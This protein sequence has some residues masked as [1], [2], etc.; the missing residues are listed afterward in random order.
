MRRVVVTGLGLV[1]P[2]GADVETVWANLIAGKSGAGTITHFDASDQKCTIACEVKGPDHE[3]GFDPGKRV[4]HTAVLPGPVGLEHRDIALIAS[5][6]GQILQDLAGRALALIPPFDGL[7]TDHDDGRAL[8]DGNHG[9][10]PVGPEPDGDL[11]R[12]HDA[13]TECC[14]N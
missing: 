8:D 6:V 3:Y 14:G 2:L 9:P 13:H 5:L 11:P 7:S 4:D 1:T 12:R 10:S